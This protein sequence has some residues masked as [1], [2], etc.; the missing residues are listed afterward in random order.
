M[1]KWAA[2]LTSAPKAAFPALILNT[3]G[4]YVE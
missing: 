3:L 1:S 4:V 2:A